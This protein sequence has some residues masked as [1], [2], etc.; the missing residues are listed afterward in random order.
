MVTCSSAVPEAGAR[1]PP[2]LRKERVF[3]QMGTLSPNPC[4]LQP[5]RQNVA[6][7]AACAALSFRPLSWRSGRIPA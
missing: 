3:F 2:W 5:S 4:D 6:K 7:R 1:R